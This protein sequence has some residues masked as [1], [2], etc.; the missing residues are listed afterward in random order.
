MKVIAIITDPGGCT[1]PLEVQK[2]LACH[3]RNKAPPF[4][5]VALKVSYSLSASE[6]RWWSMSVLINKNDLET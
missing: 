3:K 5:K 4:E 1:H 6:E 2:I